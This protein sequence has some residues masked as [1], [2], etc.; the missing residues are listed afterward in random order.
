MTPYYDHG[1]IT[2]YQGDAREIVP[3]LGMRFDACITDPPYSETSLK[4]DVWPAHW[5]EMVAEF[6]DCLWCFGSLR[7]FLDRR[8]EFQLWKFAQDVVWE[9][10][11]GSSFHADRFK[12]VHENA[13]HFY[14]G[15]WESLFRSVPTTPD[16][17]TRA[18]RRKQRPLH[19]GR[20]DES[21]YTSQDGGPRLMRSVQFHKSCH[22]YAVNETQKP[23]GIVA[24]LLEYSVPAGGIV[25]DCFAGSGTTLAVARAQGKRAV[26]IE[27]RDSQCEEAAK[28]LEQQV[29][30]L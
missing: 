18:V 1:G 29:F 16:A 27:L 8:D 7:M 6:T 10:H 17:T 13:V 21:H 25:L 15:P 20:I 26:G 19:M 2:I 4:W 5:P 22:G 14:Q 12:R 3:S 30:A 11:N 28:R 9:K 24:P 23:E